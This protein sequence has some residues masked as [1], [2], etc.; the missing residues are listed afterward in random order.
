[1]I[2]KIILFMIYIPI[3]IITFLSVL[4]FLGFMYVIFLE[5]SSIFKLN[6]LYKLKQ[7]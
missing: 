3:M 6:N 5:D 1:M 4:V 2:N 7:K